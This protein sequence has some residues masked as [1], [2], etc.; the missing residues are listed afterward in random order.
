M[1]LTADKPPTQVNGDESIGKRDAKK[2]NLKMYRS[3]ETLQQAPNNTRK[4]S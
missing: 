2:A 4:I 3:N 1:G